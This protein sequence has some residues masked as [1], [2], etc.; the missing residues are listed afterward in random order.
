MDS[1][2]PSVTVRW[3]VRAL[4]IQLEN[5]KYPSGLCSEAQNCYGSRFRHRGEFCWV[6]CF[7]ADSWL[8]IHSWA[9]QADAYWELKLFSSYSLAFILI[10]LIALIY[11][12]E[13]NSV[14]FPIPMEM[15]L[16]LSW[17]GRLSNL[18]GLKTQENTCELFPIFLP[19]C[20]PPS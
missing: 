20:C 16:I 11:N 18:Y 7:L 17:Q 12:L 10:D 9:R 5:R 14:F 8:W 2:I 6:K 19:L 15:L 3:R 1:M 13:N 4:S